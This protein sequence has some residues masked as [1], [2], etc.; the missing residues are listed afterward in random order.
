MK[1]RLFYEIKS[2]DFLEKNNLKV[3]IVNPKIVKN[4]SWMFF[5]NLNI[6]KIVFNNIYQQISISE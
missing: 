2:L 5:Q 6:V 1:A 3:Q 4:I